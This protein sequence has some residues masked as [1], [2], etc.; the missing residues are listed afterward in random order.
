MKNCFFVL[1]AIM[2]FSA[3]S[4]VEKGGLIQIDLEKD[5]PD[6][7]QE[8]SPT[9]RVGGQALSKFEKVTH[10]VPL[11]SLQDVFSKEE[12]ADFM[13]RFNPCL[14]PDLTVVSI[15]GFNRC[16]ASHVIYRVGCVLGPKMGQN[17][18]VAGRS[19]KCAGRCLEA[20][21]TLY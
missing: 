19:P 15:A 20:P 14:N 21:S 16:P 11:M 10:P 2:A 9:R 1:L 4:Q 12:L 18:K 8:D 17:M 7:V 13:V 6:L 5:Y 3:C